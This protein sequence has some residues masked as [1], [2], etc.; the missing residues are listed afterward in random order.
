[1]KVERRMSKKKKIDNKI[2]KPFAT[3]NYFSE[4]RLIY[5]SNVNKKNSRLSFQH[6]Y[7]SALWSLTDRP[8][9]KIFIK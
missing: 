7:I 6:F 9:Y 3:F 2:T 4:L 5:D 8:M 1:M